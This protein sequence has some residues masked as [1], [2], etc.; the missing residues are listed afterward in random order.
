M[1]ILVSV[2]L[3]KPFVKLWQKAEHSEII[4]VYSGKSDYK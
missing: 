2:K 1:R 3:Q 4:S